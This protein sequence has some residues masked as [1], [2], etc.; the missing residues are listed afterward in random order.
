MDDSSSN[1]E[2]EIL[3]MNSNVRCRQFASFLLCTVFLLLPVSVNAENASSTSDSYTVYLIRHAEKQRGSLEPK[4]PDLT[5]CGKQ[6]ADYIAAWLQQNGG[7]LQ[8]VY[9]SPY[10]RTEQTAA[11]TAASFGLTTIHYD[12]RE[13]NEAA[14]LLM[15]QQ[16]SA[17]VVGHSNTTPQL[18]Q[19]LTGGEVA[20]MADDQFSLL[21][22]VEINSGT[23]KLVIHRMTFDCQ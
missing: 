6:R 9:S 13:L 19:L 4:N 14:E 17:L 12:P 16:A 1:L 2:V 15:Q 7:D 20:A 21:Y 5:E 22:Q 8:A 11:A 23:P 10:K 18:T 3:P